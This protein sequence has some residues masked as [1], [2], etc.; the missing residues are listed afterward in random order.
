LAL[1][2]LKEPDILPIAITGPQRSP[3]LPEVPTFT[4]AGLPQFQAEAYFGL[5]GPAKLPPDVV[6]K[7]NAALNDSLKDPDVVTRLGSS[8]MRLAGGTPKAYGERIHADIGTWQQ[9]VKDA[10]ITAE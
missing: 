10:N 9:I 2:I 6:Q 3:S 1:P 4:E 7:L 8:G 5:L